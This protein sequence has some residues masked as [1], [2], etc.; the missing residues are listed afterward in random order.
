M[1]FIDYINNH[2]S[3]LDIVTRTTTKHWIVVFFD[4]IKDHLCAYDTTDPVKFAS[5]WMRTDSPKSQF[6]SV[7]PSLNR[8]AAED[9]VKQFRTH[10]PLITMFMKIVKPTEPADSGYQTPSV[11]PSAP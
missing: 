10:V 2:M 5:N 1:K 11:A 8:Q 6:V 9:F 4:P 7:M 3:T